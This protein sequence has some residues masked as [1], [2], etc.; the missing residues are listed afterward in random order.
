MQ[1]AQNPRVVAVPQSL[2]L[3]R[4]APRGIGIVGHHDGVRET[5]RPRCCRELRHLVGAVE[6]ELVEH[7]AVAVRAVGKVERDR[8]HR[9][10]QRGAEC[11]EV[12]L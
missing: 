6:A 10:R 7:V 5:V 2:E 9:G 12:L 1:R 3:P 11:R 8:G 4:L